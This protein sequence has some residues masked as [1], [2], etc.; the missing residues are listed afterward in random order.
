[1]SFRISA[2][3]YALPAWVKSKSVHR[4]GIGRVTFNTRS[5]KATSSPDLR[6]MSMLWKDM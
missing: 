3:S 1:M 4:D 2:K 6:K 5:F